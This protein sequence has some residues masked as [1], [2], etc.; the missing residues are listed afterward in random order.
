V[1]EILLHSALHKDVIAY[2]T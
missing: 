2:T 1:K